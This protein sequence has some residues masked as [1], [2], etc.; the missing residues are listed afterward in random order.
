MV[1]AEGHVPIQY[2]LRSGREDN[3]QLMLMSGDNV[4]PA[5]MESDEILPAW[6][7]LIRQITEK[8]DKVEESSE[9]EYLNPTPSYFLFIYFFFLIT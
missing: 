7:E 9:K 5:L 8:R 3:L 1:D 4:P 2:A 6:K